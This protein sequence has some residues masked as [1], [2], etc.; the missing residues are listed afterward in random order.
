ML[1]GSSN[2]PGDQAGQ[3]CEQEVGTEPITKQEQ[4]EHQSAFP[5]GAELVRWL[6][7]ER[8]KKGVFC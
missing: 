4:A 2:R 3:H 6:L 8:R 7:G 5:D 1:R